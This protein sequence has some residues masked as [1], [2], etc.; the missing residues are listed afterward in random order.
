MVYRSN[1]IKEN[2][3]QDFAGIHEIQPE[4]KVVTVACFLKQTQVCKPMSALR[5]RISKLISLQPTFSTIPLILPSFAQSVLFSQADDVRDISKAG[6]FSQIQ[7][8]LLKDYK[9]LG[10]FMIFLSLPPSPPHSISLMF[11]LLC[12]FSLLAA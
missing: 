8:K 12:T 5:S 6:K 1:I 11:S 3:V 7:R 2:P 9:H 4:Q 10:R